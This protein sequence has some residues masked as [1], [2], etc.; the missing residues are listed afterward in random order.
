M[1]FATPAPLKKS[2]PSRGG[3]PNRRT[4]YLLMFGGSLE[5]VHSAKAS[6]RSSSTATTSEQLGLFQS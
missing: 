5:I 4:R 6:R 3:P 1:I 2:E